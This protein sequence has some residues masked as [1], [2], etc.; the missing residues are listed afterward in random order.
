M[1]APVPSCNAIPR[2]DWTR[3]ELQSL[4]SLPFPELIY[5]AQSIHRAH[6]DPTEV[7]ISTLLSIKTGG[8][9]EDCAYCPQ[10]ASYDTGV[11]AAKLMDVDAVLADARA[12]RDAGATRFCMGAAWR[13]PKDKDLG[14]ICEMIEGVKALGM[15]SCVTLGMLTETQ[16]QRLKSS[17]L[18]YYNHNIDTSPEFYGE[19][20]TTRTYQD[21]LDTLAAVRDAGIH[22]CCG[23]IVGMGETVA[24]RVGMLHTLATMPVHPES[25]PINM[26]MQVEG[27]PV[28]K[29]QTLDPIEFVRTIAVARIA[30][31][32]SMVRL[33][34]GRE[35]MSAETQALCFLAGANS[36]FQGPKLLTTPNPAADED[37]HLFERLGMNAMAL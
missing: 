35:L 2:H 16:A 37:H 9:P 19:I 8:C 11:K 33:S 28:S 13:S 5:R 34:A 12:A 23:G 32:K 3:D 1:N 25:V 24:D 27:T 21:R 29:G 10:S 30:M 6:F 14:H 31:P 15:E 36:I 18:D 4:F 7:Q 26:L 22:V 17:G 20:I